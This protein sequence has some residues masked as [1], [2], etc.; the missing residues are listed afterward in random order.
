MYHAPSAAL[1]SASQIEYAGLLPVPRS[2]LRA[3]ASARESH[4]HGVRPPQFEEAES[5]EQYS[6]CPDTMRLL[7]I[8][9]IDSVSTE[10]SGTV[11]FDRR[12][13]LILR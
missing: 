9:A 7:G 11:V 12:L 13:R 10:G 3:P 5:D 4:A 8:V 6:G 2:A 1:A